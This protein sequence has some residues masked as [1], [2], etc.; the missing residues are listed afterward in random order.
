MDSDDWYTGAGE[1][2]RVGGSKVVLGA[3]SVPGSRPAP[4]RDSRAL[5][6]CSQGPWVG[7][8]TASPGLSAVSAHPDLKGMKAIP[9]GLRLVQV[10]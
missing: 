2:P 7:R 10:T 8:G 6:E 4:P 9:R 5:A 3:V 1:L